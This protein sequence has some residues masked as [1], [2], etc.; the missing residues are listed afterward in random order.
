MTHHV[1]LTV[2]GE[3]VATWPAQETGETDSDGNPCAAVLIFD[4]DVRGTAVVAMV[5]AMAV[6]YGWS[7]LN[8]PSDLTEKEHKAEDYLNSLPPDGWSF[9]FDQGSFFLANDAWWRMVQS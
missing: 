7:D 1:T 8:A 6:S 9:G 3:V 5:V 4:G 2:K